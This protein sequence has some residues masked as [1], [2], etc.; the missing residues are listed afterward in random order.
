MVDIIQ[1][2][3][4]ECSSYFTSLRPSSQRVSC[5]LCL[6]EIMEFQSNGQD[7]FSLELIGLNSDCGMSAPQ[8]VL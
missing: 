2:F 8:V 3:V 6:V 1:H 7:H 5:E 4:M